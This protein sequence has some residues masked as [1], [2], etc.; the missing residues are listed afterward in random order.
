MDGSQIRSGHGGEENC[1]ELK[2][3]HLVCSLLFQHVS[4][5]RENPPIVQIQNWIVNHH[6]AMF[7]KL[8]KIFRR[9]LKVAIFMLLQRDL[10]SSFLNY[11]R[12]H[13]LVCSD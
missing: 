5:E 2:P 12:M 4:R 13:P 11:N 8:K 10:N 9:D 7:H 3:G 1:Q 6:T